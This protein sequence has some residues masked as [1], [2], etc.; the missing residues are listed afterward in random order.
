MHGTSGT[1]QAMDTITTAL[2]ED[3]IW[4]YVVL[5]VIEAAL[6]ARWWGQPERRATIGLLVPLVLAGAVFFISRAVVTDRERVRAATWAIIQD[7]QDG[8]TDV[9]AEYLDDEYRGF[10]G[11]KPQAV[12]A[13]R[14]AIGRYGLRAVTVRQMEVQLVGR[15]AQMR[16]TTLIVPSK[17]QAGG[18]PVRLKWDVRWANRPQGWRIVQATVMGR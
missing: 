4:I 6:V 1:M 11:T 13:C 17:R 9:L 7:I 5:G 12:E 8:N 16:V 3:P 18:R 10:S 14:L 2:F 15:T